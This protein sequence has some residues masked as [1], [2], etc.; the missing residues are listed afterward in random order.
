[1]VVNKSSSERKLE[2]IKQ[3]IQRT[4]YKKVSSDQE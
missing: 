1:M 3:A 4:S 2:S